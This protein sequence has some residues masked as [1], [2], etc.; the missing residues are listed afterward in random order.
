MNAGSTFYAYGFPERQ[1]SNTGYEEADAASLYFVQD[2]EGEVWLVVNLD[3]AAPENVNGGTARLRAV[4]R[5]IPGRVFVAQ[6]DDLSAVVGSPWDACDGTVTGTDCFAWDEALGRGTFL[7]TW[8]GGRTDGVVLGPLPSQSFGL[9]LRFSDVAGLERLRVAS[10]VAE[11]NDVRFV[12]VPFDV[13]I[14]VEAL[15]C[16]EYCAELET[17]GQCAQSEACAWCV[18]PS[19]VG[20]CI[21]I[22]VEG[23]GGGGAARNCSLGYVE[24]GCC[25]ECLEFPGCEACIAEEEALGCGWCHETGRCISGYVDEAC[26]ACD[27]F[28]Y[29]A[30]SASPSPSASV[31]VA[32]SVTA[33][34]SA[35][36]AASPSPSVSATPSGE[37]LCY[38]VRHE[39]AVG[40]G[41]PGGA[42]QT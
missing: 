34:A 37:P 39:L 13:D 24:V 31:S 28:A 32:A 6:T 16:S 9:G 14:D 20:E 3:Q 26:E 10:Y 18:G 4:G 5:N 1:S 40:T 42:G 15:V 22:I 35:T 7:W 21:S 12:D 33:S 25:A 29:F 11:Q 36:A 38:R 30:C 19:G 8:L 2:T 41:G 27:D 17:C 23:G